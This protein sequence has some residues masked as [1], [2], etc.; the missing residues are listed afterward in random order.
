MRK[1]EV[2][3]HGV[4]VGILEEPASGGPWRFIYKPDYK[5]E[6]VSLTMPADASVYEYSEFPP[7]FE[8]LLPEGIQLEALL[9]LKKIDRDDLFG[10]LIAV[11]EDMIGAVTVKEVE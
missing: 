3:V 6:S 10:Q 11:G 7:F 2:S 5:G 1:A 4:M 8:G 9:R